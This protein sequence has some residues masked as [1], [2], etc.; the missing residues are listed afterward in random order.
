V[1]RAKHHK[2]NMEPLRI[3]NS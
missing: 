2:H 1:A 3:S